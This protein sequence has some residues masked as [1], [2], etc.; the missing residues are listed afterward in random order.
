MMGIPMGT[1]KAHLDEER[2]KSLAQLTLLSTSA[3]LTLGGYIIG[4]PEF[5]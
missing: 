1:N 5:C 4:F 3:D 2:I